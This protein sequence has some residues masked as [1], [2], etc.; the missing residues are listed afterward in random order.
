MLENIDEYFAQRIGGAADYIGLT[1]RGFYTVSACTVGGAFLASIPLI[2]GTSA[3][4]YAITVFILGILCIYHAFTSA[5][6]AGRWGLVERFCSWERKTASL[7]RPLRPL[8]IASYIAFLIYYGFQGWHIV[9]LTMIV[10]SY[11]LS[12]RAY[13]T[14]DAFRS[15]RSP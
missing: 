4:G 3:A 5:T 6:Q 13:N 15:E 14:S 8:F 1:P 10:F 9:L 2:P 11:A 7:I 12:I